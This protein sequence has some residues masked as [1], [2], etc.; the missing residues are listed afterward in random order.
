L[1][2]F[3]VPIEGV[4]FDYGST[5]ITLQRPQEQ[6]E[7]AYAN[8]REKLSRHLPATIPNPSILLRDIHDRLEAEIVSYVKS[9]EL[10]EIDVQLLEAKAWADLGVELPDWLLAEI[11]HEVQVAWWHGV[12][13]G[14]DVVETLRIL[15]EL[16]LRVGLC[17]NAPYV[18]QSM[19]AQLQHLGLLK[20]LDCAVFSSAVG[21]RKPSPILFEHAL[22]TLG[23]SAQRTV[24]VGDRIRE[25][26]QGA[27]AVGMRAIR[28]RQYFDDHSHEDVADA[29]VD[30]LAD[31][32]SLLPATVSVED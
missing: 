23:T 26:I 5:L 21:W 31:I 32:V 10:E 3:D 30:R 22:Q 13:V 28:T 6:L 11:M 1:K 12:K 9:G 19:E 4:L 27:H 14:L 8:I 7:K 16:G 2:P 20:Y 18:P 25:D 15:R 24:M 29:T 17:S